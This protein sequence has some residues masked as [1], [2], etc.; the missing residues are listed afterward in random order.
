MPVAV[1]RFQKT[2]TGEGNA[3]PAC[4]L[5]N[6]LGPAGLTATAGPLSNKGLFLW[7]E[8]EMKKIKREKNPCNKRPFDDFK[9]EI[10]RNCIHESGHIVTGL[11]LKVPVVFSEVSIKK[12]STGFFVIHFGKTQFSGLDENM[13][14]PGKK[15]EAVRLSI[16]TLWGG[17]IAEVRMY[18]PDQVPGGAQN[19][20]D[21]I[22]LLLQEIPIV[23]ARMPMLDEIG[24][25]VKK[26]INQNL[27][28]IDRL[29]FAFM[30]RLDA[31]QN[32]AR[33]QGREILSLM[34]G[35]SISVREIQ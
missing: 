6:S 16:A 2:T 19:D 11:A 29:V 28:N 20:M 4:D 7:K 13:L 27:K 5:A 9:S 1:H 23:E 34:G 21:K 3:S 15:A 22:G 35:P 18:G 26:I 17:A 12:D 10:V 32:P 31:G 30:H 25:E 33:L 8:R 24:K 14:I